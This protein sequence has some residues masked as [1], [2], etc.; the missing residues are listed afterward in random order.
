MGVLKIAAG[1]HRGVE[2]RVFYSSFSRRGT[3]LRCFTTHCPR[4]GLEIARNLLVCLPPVR[5]TFL[6]T[7]L[8]KSCSSLFMF[9]FP[10]VGELFSDT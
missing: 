8:F 5:S 7:F 6:G 10:E 9:P 3:L 2:A 1:V 4:E